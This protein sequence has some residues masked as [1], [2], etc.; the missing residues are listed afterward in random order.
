ML[1]KW[2]HPLWMEYL[3]NHW[4]IYLIGFLSLVLTA[5]MQ[6]MTVRILGW[7]IDF[8]NEKTLPRFLMSETRQETFMSL[9]WILLL[10]H[11][12]LTLGRFLWRITF[13]RQTFHSQKLLRE[14]M[15]S[16]ARLFSF[17]TFKKKYTKG[18]LLNV[19]NSEITTAS[20]IFGFSLVGL[21]DAFLLF[22]A[23]M[24]AML[25]INLEIT[26]YSL[27][28][29][30]FLPWAVYRLSMQEISA[31]D[32]AQSQ[33]E[34]LNDLAAHAVETIK[35]QKITNTLDNW[36]NRFENL[37]LSLKQKR[38]VTSLLENNYTIVIGG[39][40]LLSIVAL[41]VL[42][43]QKTLAGEMSIGDFV[44]IQGLVFL[45]Q[46]P[47]IEMGAV[48]SD[49]RKG[50]YGL[51]KVAEILN[52]PTHQ[53]GPNSLEKFPDSFEEIYRLTD[54][55]FSYADSNPI[56]SN[57]NLTI[58]KGK[59]LGILGPIGS[60]KSTL[61]KILAGLMD[62]DAGK[63]S[64]QLDLCDRP[65]AQYKRSFLH[66]QIILVN[67]TPFIFAKSVR[68]NLV[69]D[70]NYTDAEVWSA[71]ELAG[72]AEDIQ[73]LP[74]GLDTILGEMG[75]NLSGGQKQRLSLARAFILKPKILIIDD[76]FSAI[77]TLTE[78]AI[79]QKV[80]HYFKEATIIWV[81]HRMS[82]LKYCDEILEMNKIQSIN[83]RESHEHS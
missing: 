31:Y 23:T 3:K 49:F 30:S 18:Y 64:G 4:V 66:Q 21:A 46:S 8:L 28:L 44:A 50:N 69:L 45:L 24:I 82:T 5:S 52:Y 41:F 1:K 13:A 63:L 48:I 42:G 20:F 57:L 62:L 60:G 68:D 15:W 11:L 73:K 2:L 32:K 40:S 10:A 25:S 56:I 16:Q 71:L 33:Q 43:V 80:H 78:N 29:M 77:D 61:V 26:L 37:A 53:D 55:S 51:N 59:R 19:N 72:L 7:V 22:A 79:L 14:K 27:L 75:I 58:S 38:L 9:F 34:V 74:E 81:A 36:M 54:L 12:L 67:Q 6:A 65:L 35:L 70:R 76:S 83:E 39:A 17:E 47:L